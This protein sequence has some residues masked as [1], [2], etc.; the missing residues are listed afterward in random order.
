[1]A[2][3]AA[4]D[5]GAVAPII[6]TV[7]RFIQ[8][9]AA[10]LWAI[11]Q[12]CKLMTTTPLRNPGK[13]NSAW[14]LA[15]LADRVGNIKQSYF[16]ALRIAGLGPTRLEFVA[17]FAHV[18]GPRASCMRA[19]L[20]TWAIARE[21]ARF[22]GPYATLLHRSRN[23]GDTIEG[24][25]QALHERQ[26]ESPAR[27]PHALRLFGG[28][29]LW[30]TRPLAKWD[31]QLLRDSTSLEHLRFFQERK[32]SR[33][34]KPQAIERDEPPRKRARDSL[35]QLQRVRRFADYNSLRGCCSGL[36]VSAMQDER[37]GTL[38]Q[39]SANSLGVPVSEPKVEDRC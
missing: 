18:C 19:G 9:S 8:S 22:A 26:S 3:V 39:T 4:R 2:G 35:D 30:Q 37:D 1:V 28:H 21:A 7:A 16:R 25:Q 5:L 6:E 23:H 38:V 10:W 32:L 13:R 33:I 15:K 29:L 20:Q 31:R 17:A 27:I 12:P 11:G 14:P 34:A 24:T 36:L